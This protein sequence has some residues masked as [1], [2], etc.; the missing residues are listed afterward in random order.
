MIK[1]NFYNP[2]QFKNF[3]NYIN[4]RLHTTFWFISIQ[5]FLLDINIKKIILIEYSTEFSS[6][7]NI[8]Y[9]FLKKIILEGMDYI[10]L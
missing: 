6:S 8:M 2:T 3:V 4:I 7:I 10:F 5:N 9:I 1:S